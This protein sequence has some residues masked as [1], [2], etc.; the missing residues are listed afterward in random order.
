MKHYHKM[1]LTAAIALSLVGCTV[2]EYEMTNT[3]PTEVYYTN[4][5][6]ND[7]AYYH[8]RHHHTDVSQTPAAPVGASSPA[9]SVTS[10]TATPAAPM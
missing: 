10:T 8:Q 6:T 2:D 1:I 7:A 5:R 3:A 4:V 9:G